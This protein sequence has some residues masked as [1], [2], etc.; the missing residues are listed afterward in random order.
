MRWPWL[1][2]ALLLASVQPA[3]AG[4]L[5]PCGPDIGEVPCLVSAT[6]AVGDQIIELS[7]DSRIR[8]DT[9]ELDV[10]RLVVDSDP[11]VDYG[12]SFKNLLAT[13]VTFA[14]FVTTPYA[15]GPYTIGASTHA[16]AVTDA[17]PTGG[18]ADGVVTIAPNNAAAIHLPDVDGSVFGP[19]AGECSPSGLP[20]FSAD[21]GLGNLFGI[22]IATA[23][24]GLLNVTL[25][26][27]VS[28]GDRYV[29]SGLAEI[30]R[31]EEGPVVPEPA[32]GVLCGLGI[33]A[34]AWRRYRSSK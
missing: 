32:T 24:S 3:G 22:P 21:C 7:A 33:A 23:A 6:V 19:I 28:A 26:A 9:F 27:S 25:Q 1:G 2:A 30:T 5:G 4:P 14:I 20:G 8:T 29:F 16:G 31:G 10:L 18:S 34:V 13:D 12:F 11:F 15:G 17:P